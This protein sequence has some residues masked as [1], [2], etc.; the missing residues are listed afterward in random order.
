M[1]ERMPWLLASQL[2]LQHCHLSPGNR[3]SCVCSV[4]SVEQTPKQNYLWMW[5]RYI[6]RFLVSTPLCSVPLPTQIIKAL[7]LYRLKQFAGREFLGSHDRGM[8][9]SVHH[10]SSTASSVSCC[11]YI[12]ICAFELHLCRCLL[13]LNGQLLPPTRL[14]PRSSPRC[15]QSQA[16]ARIWFHPWR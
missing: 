12:S 14:K 1:T 2:A 15:L 4:H 7:V 9:A 6:Q 11:R 5:Q 10:D 3:R 8:T 13:I 16:P